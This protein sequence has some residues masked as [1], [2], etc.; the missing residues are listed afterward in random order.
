MSDQEDTE[1]TVSDNESSDNEFTN[2]TV[3]NLV[4]NFIE[5]ARAYNNRRMDVPSLT[6]VVGLPSHVQQQHPVI[7]SQENLSI[8]A[9]LE[10]STKFSSG[11]VI[12]YLFTL[13]DSK[14]LSS[15]AVKKL[16]KML[17]DMTTLDEWQTEALKLAEDPL[18]SRKDFSKLLNN[19]ADYLKSFS[20]NKEKKNVPLFDS[21][22][23]KTLLFSLMTYSCVTKRIIE[24]YIKFITDPIGLVQPVII[25]AKLFYRDVRDDPIPPKKYSNWIQFKSDLTKLTIFK[26]PYVKMSVKKNMELHGFF[27]VSSKTYGVCIYLR[28]KEANKWKIRLFRAE[29]KMISNECQSSVTFSNKLMAAQ[30]LSK[31]MLRCKI[32][33]NVEPCNCYYWSNHTD[34]LAQIKSSSNQEEVKKIQNISYPQAWHEVNS[35]DNPANLVLDGSSSKSLENN[36]QWWSGPSWLNGELPVSDEESATDSNE[37]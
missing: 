28:S 33:T 13:K 19:Q 14:E 12:S 21:L 22:I 9:L 17:N 24:S 18:F 5:D 6:S 10:S 37:E 27:Q 7:F 32:E 26:F 1:Q 36:S 4:R 25:R 34:V 31:L 35:D 15:D 11:V 20:S 16:T 2:F 3:M 8:F 30:F 29:F 23:N